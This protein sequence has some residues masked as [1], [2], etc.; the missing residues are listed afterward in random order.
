MGKDGCNGP[1]PP[2]APEFGRGPLLGSVTRRGRRGHQFELAWMR[3]M[4][5]L[6]G[7]RGENMRLAECEPPGQHQENRRML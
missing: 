6:T 3:E 2:P 4:D 1:H 5:H 7:Q